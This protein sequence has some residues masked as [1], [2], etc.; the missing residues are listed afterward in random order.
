M[1]LRYRECRGIRPSG[2]GEREIS[3]KASGSFGDRKPSDE[4]LPSAAGGEAGILG[5]ERRFGRRLREVEGV[6][7]GGLR[8]LS[9]PD[10]SSVTPDSCCRRA[11]DL[12]VGA[13]YPSRASD[14]SDNEGEGDM[15]RGVSGTVFAVGDMSG[16]RREN[17]GSA[18]VQMEPSNG[19]AH[20]SAP[21]QA[22]LPEGMS[23]LPN[24]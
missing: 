23:D 11:A 4:D 17:C 2:D 24:D 6:E 22:R 1:K 20:D 13:K 12:V 10:P 3:R 8:D 5:L 19:R 16:T 9:G 14:L 21:S 15:T 7:S 18:G